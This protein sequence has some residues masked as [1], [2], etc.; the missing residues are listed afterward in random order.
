MSVKNSLWWVGWRNG[1]W[2]F[3]LNNSQMYRNVSNYCIVNIKIDCKG[4]NY[5]DCE[6]RNK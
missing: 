1:N 5:Y 3:E 6:N 2:L 4:V